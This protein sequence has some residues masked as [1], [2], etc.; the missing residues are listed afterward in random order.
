M[1]LQE[2]IKKQIKIFYDS[3]NNREKENLRNGKR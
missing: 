1:H 3:K 2:K